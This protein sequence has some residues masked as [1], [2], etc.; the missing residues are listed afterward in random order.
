MGN[1]LWKICWYK[2][3]EFIVNT[4]EIWTKFAENIKTFKK[5]TRE[6][7]AQSDCNMSEKS[8]YITS[9]DANV[10]NYTPD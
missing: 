1:S 5:K 9:Y 4:H 7:R 3:G 6:N 2:N 10:T 8:K